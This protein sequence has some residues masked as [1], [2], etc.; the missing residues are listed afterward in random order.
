MGKNWKDLERVAGKLFGT[1]RNIGSGTMGRHDHEGVDV[2]H[3]ELFI[4]CKHK[5]AYAPLLAAMTKIRKEAAKDVNRV[6]VL[7]L[8]GSGDKPKPTLV[9]HSDDLGRL[10]EAMLA[11]DGFVQLTTTVRMEISRFLR[12]DMQDLI[13]AEGLLKKNK[14]KVAVL[15]M[16]KASTP[17]V[18][19]AFRPEHISTVFVWQLAGAAVVAKFGGGKAKQETPPALMRDPQLV[20]QL[21]AANSTLQNFDHCWRPPKVMS[22]AVKAKR[23]AKKLKKAE[24]ESGKNGQAQSEGS[25]ATPAQ[26]GGAAGHQHAAGAGGDRPPA[27]GGGAAG[28]RHA[29]DPAVQPDPAAT[30]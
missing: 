5:K 9:V 15:A 30:K 11:A 6:G 14:K 19:M 8:P 17:G 22:D 28:D 29:G 13:D 12:R 27:D 18:F 25:A 1:M 2:H 24:K 10:V 7:L 21:T 20:R 4:E 23:D 26:S 3:P 16:R